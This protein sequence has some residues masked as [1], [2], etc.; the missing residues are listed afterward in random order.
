ME[1]EGTSETVATSEL[2]T[3]PWCYRE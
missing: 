2:C 3:A 1:K